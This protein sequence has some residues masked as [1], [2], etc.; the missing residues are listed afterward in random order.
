MPTNS[1]GRMEHSACSA[2]ALR[3]SQE[4]Q[5]NTFR[6]TSVWGQMILSGSL[7]P[8]CPSFTGRMVLRPVSTA[9]SMY[10]YCVAHSKKLTMRRTEA[11]T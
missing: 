3:S 1:P 7:T 4:A 2:M 9:A 10:S 8:R 5:A 6:S 11:L